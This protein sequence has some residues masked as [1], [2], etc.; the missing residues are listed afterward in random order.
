MTDA[1]A[2]TVVMAAYN[3]AGTIGQAIGSVL[4]QTREDWELVVVDDGSTDDTAAIASSFGDE[5]IRIVRRQNGGPAAARNAGIAAARTPL[6]S[7]LDSDDLWLPGY[8]ETM[9]SILAANPDAVLAYTDAWVIDD[10]KGRVRKTTEMTYQRPPVPPPTMP[11]AFL[12]ELLKRNFIYNS[13]TVRR[14]ALVE[15]GGYDERLRT[16][17]DWELWLR[18]AALG[19]P[20]LRSPAALAVH[21]DRRGSLTTD[22]DELQ[23]SDQ[24]VYRIV[25]EDWETDGEIR[26]LARQLAAEGRGGRSRLDVSLARLVRPVRRRLQKWTLWHRRP[27][28]EIARLLAAVSGR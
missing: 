1:A 16:S 24:A 4:L 26:A 22:L 3:S 10:E 6:V 13:V 20:C 19:R 14:E 9:T 27:P 18:L 11:R 12:V 5:R 15:T 8:L 2:V 25:Q 7:M 23:R 17:E 28:T 21:R